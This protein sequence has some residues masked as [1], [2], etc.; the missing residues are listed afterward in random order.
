MLWDILRW[1]LIGHLCA[2]I[3]SALALSAVTLVPE[4]QMGVFFCIITFFD[5]CAALSLVGVPIAC[6]VNVARAHC[7]QFAI[8]TYSYFSLLVLVLIWK[9]IVNSERAVPH[10]LLLSRRLLTLVEFSVAL[11]AYSVSG[12]WRFAVYGFVF[13]VVITALSEA[14]VW[15]MANREKTAAYSE[16][17]STEDRQLLQGSSSGEQQM[18][19]SNC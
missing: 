17:P 8:V 18:S 2:V 14:P 12:D 4:S 15:Y 9:A 3:V 6:V 1:G 10:H 13:E 7:G 5:T 19:A 16:S 11:A